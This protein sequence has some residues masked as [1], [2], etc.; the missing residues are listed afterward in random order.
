[1]SF[2]VD[3]VCIVPHIVMPVTQVSVVVIHHIAQETAKLVE[4]TVAW[5]VLFLQPE[6]PLPDD[7]AVIPVST[8]YLWKRDGRR[9]EIPPTILT[10]ST[11]DPWNPHQVWVAPCQQGSTTR[12]THRGVRIELR[13]PYALGSNTVDVGGLDIG[14]IVDR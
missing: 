14:A 6:V 4:S 2:R 3:G 5:M 12:R 9:I 10:V 13:E 11:Y 1:M 7:C 8:Q